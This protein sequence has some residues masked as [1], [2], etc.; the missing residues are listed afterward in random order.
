MSSFSITGL[1]SAWSK[2]QRAPVLRSDLLWAHGT[3]AY[4]TIS[5]ATRNK[6][7]AT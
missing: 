1:T 7:Q 4:I 6:G 5:W 3:L 2:A